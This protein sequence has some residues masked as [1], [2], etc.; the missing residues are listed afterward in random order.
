MAGVRLG[1]STVHRTTED[2]GGRLEDRLRENLPRVEVI[3]LD[4]FHPAAK[5]TALSHLLHPQDE[6][7]AEDQ[8]RQ[9]CGLLKDEGGAVLAAV[10]SAWDWP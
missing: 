5:L 9:W 3:L 7:R 2:A 1:E 10:L 4:F 6:D 8:A